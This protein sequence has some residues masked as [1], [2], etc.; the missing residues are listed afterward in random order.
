MLLAVEVP[1]KLEEW[2]S[3]HSGLVNLIEMWPAIELERCSHLFATNNLSNYFLQ[4]S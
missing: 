1:E 3:E 2:N 4:I